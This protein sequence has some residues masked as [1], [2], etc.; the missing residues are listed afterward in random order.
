MAEPEPIKFPPPR[1][2][3]APAL[4]LRV[5]AKENARLEVWAAR[6]RVGYLSRL[7][8]RPVRVVLQTPAPKAR[9]RT[10]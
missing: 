4:T 10:V 6:E 2:T 9:R 5:Q 1:Q 8:G 3:S 7:L